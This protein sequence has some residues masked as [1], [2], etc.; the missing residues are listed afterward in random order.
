MC[1]YKLHQML[2]IVF[3]LK[4]LQTKEKQQRNKITSL[5]KSI[6]QLKCDIKDK[7]EECGSIQAK[8]QAM[9]SHWTISS[10][11]YVQKFVM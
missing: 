3:F 7:E 8:F 11:T 10:K 9:V 1:P 5:H 2:D 4:Y 6:E